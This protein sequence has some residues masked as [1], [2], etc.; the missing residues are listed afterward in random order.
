MASATGMRTQL[1][2]LLLCGMAAGEQDGPREN[3]EP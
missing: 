2:L 1:V 3:A